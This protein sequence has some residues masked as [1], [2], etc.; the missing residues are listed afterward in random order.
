MNR[1]KIRNRYVGKDDPCLIMVDAGVN[2]NN[3]PA[4]AIE[5]VHKSADAG[6]D[7]VKFQT[8]NANNIT[9]KNIN[10]QCK[11]VFCKNLIICLFIC[12][13]QLF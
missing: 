13:Y 10:I 12:I 7:V 5:L 3:D 2:H 6:A 11:R 9:T 4:R 1:L 8:Y